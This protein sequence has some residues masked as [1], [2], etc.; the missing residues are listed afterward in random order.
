LS[1]QDR[2]R[3]G[4]D[5]E[6]VST[7]QKIPHVWKPRCIAAFLPGVPSVVKIGPDTAGVFRR[8]SADSE[9]AGHDAGQPAEAPV[10]V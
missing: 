10:A 6:V 8:A 3:L 7:L 5:R 4:D 1:R 9:R 2:D